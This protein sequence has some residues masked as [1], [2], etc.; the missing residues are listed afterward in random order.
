MIALKL[1]GILLLIS[2]VST[3]LVFHQCIVCMYFT[4]ALTLNAVILEDDVG[5]NVKFN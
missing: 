2:T 5:T 3:A 4:V 1:V